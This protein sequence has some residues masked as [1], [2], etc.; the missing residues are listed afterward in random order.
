MF[1]IAVCWSNQKINSVISP[2]KL[3]QVGKSRKSISCKGLI[4]ALVLLVVLFIKYNGIC[5]TTDAHEKVIVHL[6]AVEHV[7]VI[8][9]LGQAGGQ[10]I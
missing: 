9:Y 8:L 2:R 1:E 6:A 7:F 5:L 4:A 3:G 10:C